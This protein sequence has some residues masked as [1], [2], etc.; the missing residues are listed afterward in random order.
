MSFPLMLA[1]AYLP[2]DVVTQGQKLVLMKICD[3]VE[4]GSQTARPGLARLATWAGVSDKRAV[5]IVT[6]LVAKGLVE[7]VK[8]G[9][10]G[11]AAVYRVFPHG[12]PPVPDADELKDRREQER[13]APKNP[14][15]ARTGVNRAAP[16]KP[17]MTSQDV[18][19]RTA[20]RPVV[21]RAA[22]TAG[23]PEQETGTGFH[24]H[25][26]DSG[27][28]PDEARA[29]TP[30]VE[31]PVLRPQNPGGSTGEAPFFPVP[32]Y[33]LPYPP[34]PGD[35]PAADAHAETGGRPPSGCQQP[36]PGSEAGRQ[37]PVTSP[38]PPVLHA[39]TAAQPPERHAAGTSGR[40]VAGCE[41]PPVPGPGSEGPPQSA[42]PEPSGRPQ[43]LAP[44]AEDG[45]RLPSGC[46]KH[47][48]PVGNCR[49]CGTNPRAGREQ[50]RRDAA[51]R[52]HAA[53]QQWL[54]EF[55]AE[56][57]RRVAESDPQALQEAR[58]HVRELA[59]A[60]RTRRTD[61]TVPRAARARRGAGDDRQ[62]PVRGRD[63]VRE[64]APEHAEWT[65][66]PSEQA[67]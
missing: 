43:P 33:V 42:R 46:L 44:A 5:T 37:P 59:R 31:P 18:H 65:N 35:S 66:T 32:S 53:H 49:G 3:S 27:W 67:S 8:T 60:G 57:K 54:R 64:L 38:E 63:S 14:R 23:I 30:P 45:G 22:H 41:E 24:E 34:P 17:A 56:Q 4:D 62:L 29:G 21:R 20:A 26:P 48:E 36:V 55:F 40:P 25:A 10:G 6:E 16:S 1:A 50:A 2:A 58:Q 47:P 13:A 51:E 9:R 19:A 39:D 7:R 11:R 12:V 52:E 28:N 15:M 61:Q